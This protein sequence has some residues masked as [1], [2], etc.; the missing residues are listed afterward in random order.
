MNLEELKE[1]LKKIDLSNIRVT[2]HASKRIQDKRRKI[3]YNKIVNLI[4]SQNGLYKFEEQSAKNSNEQKFKLW[5]KLNYIYDM[6]IYVVVI[7]EKKDLNS[8]KII[9]AHKVK[10][11]I[12]EKINKNES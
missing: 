8:L 7:I 2:R 6:N 1:K 10:R 4:V 9:S 12:Q 3:N 11:K 5:F